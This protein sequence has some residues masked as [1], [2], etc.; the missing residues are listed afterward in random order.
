MLERT[1]TIKN[2]SGLHAR[3]ASLFVKKAG[4]FKCSIKL[5]KDNQVIDAKSIISLLSLGV[6]NG[7][8]ITIVTDGEDE[9]AAID[10]LLKLLDEFDD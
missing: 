5:K 2:R 3:P 8:T 4:S 9:E 1:S 10:E 6:S 7:S